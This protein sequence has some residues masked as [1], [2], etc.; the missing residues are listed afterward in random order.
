PCTCRT[1]CSRKSPPPWPAASLCA[2]SATVET[3]SSSKR[4]ASARKLSSRCAISTKLF[5]AL[6]EKT[7]RRL[8][9]ETRQSRHAVVRRH[10]RLGY[11]LRSG[12]GAVIRLHLQRAR[13]L[14]RRAHAVP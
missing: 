14:A 4:C 11:L 12:L 7:H 13:A 2:S 10:R 3:A 5:L 6:A 9:N 8:R 1:S